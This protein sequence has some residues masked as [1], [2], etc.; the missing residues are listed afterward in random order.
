MWRWK[1]KAAYVH[2]VSAHLWFC[3]LGPVWYDVE[4]DSLPGPGQ[5]H[6]TYQQDEHQ[7]VGTGRC[8]VHHLQIASA[9]VKPVAT[10]YKPTGSQRAFTKPKHV[11][12]FC[13]ESKW[14]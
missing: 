9:D 2:L 5:R 11:P 6:A 4:L 7:H 14:V 12:T 1:F 13:L 3:D 8:E 10:R